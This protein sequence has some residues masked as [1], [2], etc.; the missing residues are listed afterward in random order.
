MKTDEEKE[1]LVSI[2]DEINNNK[3]EAESKEGESGS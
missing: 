3:E 2:F 1:E